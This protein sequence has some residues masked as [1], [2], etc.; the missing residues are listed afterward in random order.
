MN[1]HEEMKKYGIRPSKYRD[2]HFL[3]DEGWQK[4]IVFFADLKDEDRVLEI[5]AGLGNLTE[6]IA[7][8]TRVYAVERDRNLAD[9][10]RIKD[11]ENVEVIE[12]DI[13][14]IDLEELDFNKVVS[15]LPYSISTPITFKLLE[16]DWETAVLVYQKE[17][18][19]RMVAEPGSS[20]YS[21][22]SL[23]IN[24]Y[25]ETQLLDTIP[26]D[27]YYPKP[28]VDSAIVRLKKKDVEAKS[29]RFWKIVKAAF[30]HRK[31]KLKNSL[32]DSSHML[33]IEEEEI[34]DLEDELPDKRTFQCDVRDF[35]KV[36][37]LFRS[38][39]E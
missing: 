38:R 36:E 12:E 1:I 39:E 4:R 21:R 5:G 18:A 22:L 8:K 23:A 10:L 26:A 34:K 32:K 7:R 11:M 19:E 6:E 28:E 14:E 29:D 35:E 20:D 2:Q 13:L 3:Q 24:Y 25:C 15:N 9:V 33:R 17:F 31:K 16:E 37:E 30:Q 27:K